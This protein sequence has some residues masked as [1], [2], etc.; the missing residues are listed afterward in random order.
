VPPRIASFTGRA[1]QLDKLDTF[2]MRDKPAAMT[3]ASV[4]RAAVQGMN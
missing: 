4:G 2:L 1:E 3:Q